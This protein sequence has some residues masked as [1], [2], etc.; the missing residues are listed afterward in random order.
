M[1]ISD[2]QLS[3]FLDA[4][5]PEAE[6]E[7]VRQGLID[8]EN[9]ANRLAELAMVDEQIASHYAQ[10]DA[11]PMPATIA[12]LLAQ[13]PESQRLT[14]TG[15][16]SAKTAT[17]PAQ[18]NNVIQFPFWKN[19]HRGLQQHA[20]LAASFMLVIGFGAVQLLPGNNPSASN[21]HAIAQVL[22]QNISGN[23]QHF[24]DGSSVKPRLTFIDNK[25]NYCRQY[26][27]IQREYSSENIACRRNTQWELVTSLPQEALAPGDYQTASG[28]SLLDTALDEMMQSDAFDAPAEQA[29][30][31]ARWTK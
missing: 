5:L 18:D 23:A 1:T 7:L 17:E 13:Q 6:M 14:Q 25:G 16:H 11:R 30:I 27:V 12:Q 24:D 8:D 10:I 29:L 3:A 2:E 15:P 19:V 9:L 20:A 28:S 4:E 31:N 26:Q 21:W 22:E